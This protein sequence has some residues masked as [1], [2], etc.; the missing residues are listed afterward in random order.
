MTTST[1]AEVDRRRRGAEPESPVAELRAALLEMIRR[2]TKVRFPSPHYQNDPVS[3]AREILGVE[4]WAKQ[5]EILEMVRDSNR[6]AVKSGHRVGKSHTIAMLAI[7]F[8][9]SFE[10]ARVVLSSTTSRQVDA[11]LWRDVKILRARAGRC[12]P[13][14]REDPDGERIPTPCPHSAL[15]DGKLGE[16]ARSGLTSG[17]REIRGFTAREAEAIT[18]IAGKN[19]LFM[20][21]EASGVPDFI[22]QAMA[23]NRAGGGRLVLFGNPTKNQGEFYEAFHKKADLYRTLTVSSEESPNVIEGRQVIQGLA[24]RDWIEE[25]KRE[26]GEDSAFYKVRVKGEHAEHEE[27]KIFPLHR[28]AEAEQRWYE[29]PEAGRLF[30]GLD[31]A[32]A[33]GTGDETVFVLRRGLRALAILSARGLTEEGHLTNLLLHLSKYKVPREVPVVVVDR[34]GS[35]GATVFGLLKMH[36]E[37]HRGAFELVGLRS[38]DGAHRQPQIFGRMRDELAQ[39]LDNWFRDGGAIPEDSKLEKDLHELEWVQS[40]SGK[41]KLID[42]VELRKRLG[43]SPDRYDA[44]ALSTWEPLSLREDKAPGVDYDDVEDDDRGLDPYG[45][46]IDPYEGSR[47]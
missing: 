13:C 27:G 33:S 9:C 17:F 3:F 25:M 40:A 24:E 12:A 7:W 4:P 34:E 19:L 10:D 2:A 37:R 20:L 45:G 11:I 14:K 39:N 47:Q 22:F 35:V 46:S 26:W 41:M 6:V 5:V 38:S 23:G 36:A 15:V 8:Y 29:T 31:P 44:L 16:L 43:R 21:D 28:I 1:A 18:G 32:G 30:V 42:K